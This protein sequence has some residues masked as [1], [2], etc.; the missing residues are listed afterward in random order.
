E[1]AR[2]C[3]EESR[4]L[5]TE[6]GDRWNLASTLNNLG[7]MACALGDLDG[8]RTLLEQAAAIQRGMGDRWSLAYT[9]NN[10]GVVLHEKQDEPAAR[11]F[12]AAEALREATGTPML[13]E[14]EALNAPAI[15]ATRG[16]LGEARFEAAWHAGRSMSLERAIEEAMQ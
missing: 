2:A 6:M 16:A 14:E 1:M 10:L 11:L 4:R 8:A 7:N 15:A 5:R 3:Y 12:G 9:L 13:P